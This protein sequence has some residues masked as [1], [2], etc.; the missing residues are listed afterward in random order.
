M[1]QEDSEL[2]HKGSELED[3]KDALALAIARG[4]SVIAWARKNGVPERTAFRWASDPQVR[5]SSETWRRNALSQAIGRM[6]RRASAAADG[7]ERLAKGAESESVRLS[8]WRAI[9]SDQISVA[10]FSALEARL[11]EVEEMLDGKAGADRA[12]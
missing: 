2:E 8:A 6:A 7:I 11:L 12:Q 10:K 9:L 1:H 4:Q 3:K 5:K